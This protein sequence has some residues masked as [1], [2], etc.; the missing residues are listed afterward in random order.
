VFGTDVAH[1]CLRITDFG[2]STHTASLLCGS[3][4][5]DTVANPTWAAPETRAGVLVARGDVYALGIVLWELAT[6][7]HPFALNDERPTAFMA[8]L[9][10]DILRGRRPPLPSGL[11]RAFA[12]AMTECWRP[13]RFRPNAS[14]ARA[15]VEAAA[16]GCGL[17]Q[18]AVNAHDARRAAARQLGVS[19]IVRHRL[20]E[21]GAVAVPAPVAVQCALLVPQRDQL[22]IGARSGGLLVYDVQSGALRHRVPLASGSLDAL[23]LHGDQRV[24]RR[25]RQRA[26]VGGGGV[27]VAHALERAAPA[28]GRR[29]RPRARVR[30][31]DG[32]DL[33]PDRAWHAHRRARADSAP[34]SPSW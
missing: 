5:A 33:P 11:P 12:H 16:L 29:Q 20:H 14:G 22:W 24:G 4:A 17:H 30:A 25:Q 8:S 34:R 7:R 10:L 19:R 28:R 13:L 26:R 9:E 31:R 18:R 21:T 32:R 6:R 15:L 27:R 1:T 3:R 2:C 23:A